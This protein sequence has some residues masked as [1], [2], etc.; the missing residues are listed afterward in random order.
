M[1]ED[2]HS[3]DPTPVEFDDSAHI[4]SV[5]FQCPNVMN[6]PP[7]SNLVVK[8]T[9]IT[10]NASSGTPAFNKLVMPPPFDIL[11]SLPLPEPP[12]LDF[13]G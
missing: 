8:L 11:P 3:G 7:V 4:P 12:P 10:H 6:D 13:F 1:C 5:G 2:A 9:S